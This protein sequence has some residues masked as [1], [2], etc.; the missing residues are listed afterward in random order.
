MADSSK[1]VLSTEEAGRYRQGGSR[2]NPSQSSGGGM[3]TTVMLAIMVAGLAG[4]GWFIAN[5]HQSMLAAVSYTHLT[6]P[7]NA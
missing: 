5:Q 2:R 1:D 7:T 6:L 3:G 4:A